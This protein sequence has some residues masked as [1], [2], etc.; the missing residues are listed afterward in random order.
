MRYILMTYSDSDSTLFAME[1]DVNMKAYTS[2]GRPMYTLCLQHYTMESHRDHPIDFFDYAEA[3][4]VLRRYSDNTFGS[5]DVYEIM[6]RDF[7][8]KVK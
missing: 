1:K 2:D 8:R 4:F 6:E 7:R 5:N 3:C